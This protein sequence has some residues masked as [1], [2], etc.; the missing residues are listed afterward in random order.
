MEMN[1]IDNLIRNPGIYYDDK[2]MDGFVQFCEKELTLTNGSDLKLLET[3]KLWTEQIFG[4][5]YFEERT[6]YKPNQDGHG[7]RYV[8][9]Q[10]PAGAKTVSDRGAWCSQEHVRQL[11]AAV[12]PDS[13][14]RNDQAA[15]YGTQPNAAGYE[16]FY[17]NPIISLL[18]K[19]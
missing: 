12:F 5:Y 2:A 15:D 17:C 7:G 6:V 11:R 10:A 3:F 19:L 14:P 13:R 9:H 18:E 8:Q 4:W 1:R 16:R